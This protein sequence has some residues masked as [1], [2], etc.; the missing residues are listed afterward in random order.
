MEVCSKWSSNEP[1]TKYANFD[2]V[3]EGT[4]VTTGPGTATA[5]LM[6]SVKSTLLK[7]NGINMVRRTFINIAG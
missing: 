7:K 2:A 4:T 6:L 3:A 5:I 1:F